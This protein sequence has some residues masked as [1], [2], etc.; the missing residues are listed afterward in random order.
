MFFSKSQFRAGCT[1]AI[2]L[3]VTGYGFSQQSIPDGTEGEML[4]V[5]K[6]D[7]VLHEKWRDKRWLERRNPI[8]SK[9]DSVNFIITDCNFPI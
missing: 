3:I 7:T 4:E 9:Q 8:L 5:V 6:P 1:L 2:V